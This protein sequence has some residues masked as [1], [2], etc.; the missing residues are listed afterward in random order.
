MIK[1]YK[2]IVLSV[3]L[4]GCETLSPTSRNRPEIGVKKC[5]EN[6]SI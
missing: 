6:I 2:T 4:N 1:I 3:V 5:A